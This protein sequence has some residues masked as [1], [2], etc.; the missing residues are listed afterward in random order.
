MAFPSCPHPTQVSR[1]NHSFNQYFLSTYFRH[2]GHRKNK[3][4]VLPTR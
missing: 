1:L 3:T 2:W 4:K